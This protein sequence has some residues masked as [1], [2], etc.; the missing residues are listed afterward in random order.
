[1][2]IPR[3][4]VKLFRRR[5]SKRRHLSAP[6]PPMGTGNA[7]TAAT[8]AAPINTSRRV[9][10]SGIIEFTSGRRQPCEH[11]P[12]GVACTPDDQ[13]GLAP[14][15]RSMPDSPGAR[16]PLSPARATVMAAGHA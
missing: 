16:R 2:E 14:F 9:T 6:G 5:G 11:N 15:V 12:L 1:R 8:D 3:R 7:A 13:T 10:F 4:Y